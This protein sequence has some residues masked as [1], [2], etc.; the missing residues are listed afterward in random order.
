MENTPPSSVTGTDG[1][2]TS[3]VVSPLI[4]PP[5]QI[6]TAAD[7]TLEWEQIQG[8]IEELH[9]LILQEKVELENVFRR[10]EAGLWE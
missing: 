10:E 4:T 6:E 1:D 3:P 9:R 8:E 5:P 7:N 2:S